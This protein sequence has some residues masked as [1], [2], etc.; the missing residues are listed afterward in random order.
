MR[1]YPFSNIGNSCYL[2]SLMQCLLS[3]RS[4][5]EICKVS[6]H[7]LL[8]RI[9]E[10]RNNLLEV[11]RQMPWY[12]PGSQ[13][14]VHESLTLLLETC[15]IGNF[16][17]RRS[18]VRKCDKCDIK[19]IVKE[20]ESNILMIDGDLN[21]DSLSIA[22]DDG[23]PCNCG[24]RIRVHY[25]LTKVSEVL[26]VAFNKFIKKSLTIYPANINIALK[27]GI[28]AKYTLKAQLEHMG[29][30]SGGHYVARVKRDKWYYANDS[31]IE[32]IMNITINADVFMLFY[33]LNGLEKMKNADTITYVSN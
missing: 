8:N 9:L 24:G 17:H 11:A 7:P 18:I 2:N 1:P 33:E 26:V 6:V 32:D 3:L 23:G 5:T 10:A 29:N 28:L 21:P 4:F 14:C 16:K 20:D 15:G 31:H 25:I 13:E 30:M 19:Q 12:R 27:D 22:I